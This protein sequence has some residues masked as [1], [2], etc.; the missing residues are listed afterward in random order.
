MTT[1]NYVQPR[2]CNVKYLKVLY[3]LN[4]LTLD[5]Q[6]V[7]AALAEFDM[8]YPNQYEFNIL[9]VDA[10]NTNVCQGDSGGPLFVM[11]GDSVE[12]KGVAS[13]VVGGCNNGSFAGYTPVGQY[14]DW[15]QKTIDYA[16]YGNTW[17]PTPDPTEPSLQ[18]TTSPVDGSTDGVYHYSFNYMVEVITF[19]YFV[20]IFV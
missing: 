10:I 7:S 1:L 8:E 18:P 16:V 14:N 6:A 2:D 15:I 13:F 4:N 12:I 20:C 17:N 11:N 3:A 9:C 5:D 19:C